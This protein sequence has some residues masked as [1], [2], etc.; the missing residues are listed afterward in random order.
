MSK[1]WWSGLKKPRYHERKDSRY[2]S[3]S[4]K[5]ISRYWE[6]FAID[7]IPF[8]ASPL[9]INLLKLAFFWGSLMTIFYRRDVLQVVSLEEQ[10]KAL[11]LYRRD[12]DFALERLHSERRELM[13]LDAPKPEV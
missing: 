10:E 11:D 13:K 7:F 2:A 6:E 3:R 1:A 12:I 4:V 9:Q 8:G 5:K